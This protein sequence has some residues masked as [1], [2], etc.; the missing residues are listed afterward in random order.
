MSVPALAAYDASQVIPGVGL[1][2][3]ASKVV[4]P[5]ARDVDAHLYGESGKGEEKFEIFVIITYHYY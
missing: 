5:D 1:P 3:T 2:V 4:L